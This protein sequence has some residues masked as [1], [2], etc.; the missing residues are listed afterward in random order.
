MMTSILHCSAGMAKPWG[1]RKLLFSVVLF[2][3]LLV[4]GLELQAT[5]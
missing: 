3:V 5:R 1:K 4:S 2:S